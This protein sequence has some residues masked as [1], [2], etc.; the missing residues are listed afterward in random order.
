MLQINDVTY[1]IGGR[2]LLD[3]ATVAVDRGRRIGLVGPNGTGKTTLLRLITGEISPDEGAIQVPRRWRIGTVPQEAPD[4]PE[5]LLATVLAADTERAALLAEAETAA[6]PHR[7]AEIHTRLADI[8]A[9]SAEA[10]AAQILAGLGFDEAAQNG[11]C[12]ALSGGL[13]MRV[14]LAATLF[15]M[16]D[17]LLLDEP[18]NH[19]D[20]EATLWLEGFLKSYPHTI[21]MVSHD[22]DLLNRA[23]DGIVHLEAA[24][25][26]LYSGGYDTFERTRRMKLEH[27]SALAQKQAAQR[28][29]M[30]EFVDRFRYKASKARQ[31]QSRLKALEKMEPIV[32]V[33][34][35][36]TVSFDFPKPDPL[37]PPLIALDDAQAGY[38]DRVVLHDLNL[39]ID[40]DDRIALL[41]ANGNGKSTFVKLLADRLR[42]M[43]GKLR[44]SSK[45]KVGYFAQHQQDELNLNRTALA[46]AQAAMPM[47][48]EEKVRSHLGRFGFPQDKAETRIADMSGGEKA[49]LLFALMSREAPHI[50]LLDEPTNHL[51][52]D[53]R[54][55]LVQA[56][57]AY[58]GAVVLITH[59]PHLVETTADR[60]WLVAD[61]T[62]KAFDGD[63]DDYRR[64]LRDQ[65]RAERSA[66]R[67]EKR[68]VKEDA[69]DRITAA[70]RRDQRR[71]AAEARAQLAPLRKQAQAAE[72]EIAT[73]EAEKARLEARLAD[74]TL[75]D[76]PA[77]RVTAL[78]IE[79]GEVAKKLAETEELWLDLHE[80]LEAS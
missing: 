13:R 2:V 49:R 76:G 36:R 58:D 31:A 15:T 28:R 55:A 57:N 41:G 79:L 24:K 7:I 63:I 32:T 22:R 25:L 50:L 8:D 51:D 61:G 52:V 18:T 42:P 69:A 77:E 11:P 27:M 80:R 6:D 29:H 37:S 34:E 66:D 78:Q 74:P 75:Y 72:R 1:R 40:M 48:T 43:A 53:S 4:G 56:I 35:N 33:A 12:S 71:A 30:Q 21:L 9:H 47:A 67:A 73:L 16:P 64:L 14:A 19:L 44:K 5:S 62:V 59:D 23:V 65:R 45:L 38:G 60:L 68:A 3:R 70:D 10:R 39:R 46:E 20:L 17:L 54:Q 26:V